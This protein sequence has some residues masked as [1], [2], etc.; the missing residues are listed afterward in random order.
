[1]MSRRAP[2]IAR[3]ILGVITP[4]TDR[5]WLLDDFDEMYAR[6]IDADG[7]MRANL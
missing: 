2:R 3:L 7:L 5:A 1:M 4:P 6:R